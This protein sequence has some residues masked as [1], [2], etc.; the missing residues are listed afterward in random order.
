[1]SR[2]AC[3]LTRQGVGCERLA[4]RLL[5]VRLM[6]RPIVTPPGAV[7]K[8]GESLPGEEDRT[9]Q[10]VRRGGADR[11]TPR[12]KLSDGDE[13]RRNSTRPLPLLCHAGY[14]D[15]VSRPPAPP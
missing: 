4:R 8:R 9:R 5:A 10:E 3:L 6:Q 1:M 11:T 14:I 15:A 13:A 12:N 2:Y 7:V